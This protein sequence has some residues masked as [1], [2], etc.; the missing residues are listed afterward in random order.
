MRHVIC[1]LFSPNEQRGG[2]GGALPDFLFCS[3]FPVQQTTSGTGH[4]VK[5]LVV[6]FG[7]TTNTLR[8][9]NNNNNNITSIDART[10]RC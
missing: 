5:Y 2:E 7:L 9:R 10:R 1:I 6:I 4:H 8:V 3:L